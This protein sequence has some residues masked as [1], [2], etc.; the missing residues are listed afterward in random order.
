M[1]RR[2]WLYVPYRGAHSYRVLPLDFVRGTYWLHEEGDS[3]ILRG[4]K[5]DLVWL[6]YGANITAL[7]RTPV[8]C[9]YAGQGAER[10]E[11][12]REGCGTYRAVGYGYCNDKDL[13]CAA[14][15]KAGECTGTNSEV[16]KQKCPHTCGVCTHICS[17]LKKDCDGW[18]RAGECKNSPDFMLAQCPTSCGLC[19]P[20]CADIHTNCNSWKSSGHAWLLRVRLSFIV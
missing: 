9:I 18:R 11:F 20:Q 4:E 14:W 5:E 15:G 3:T 10:A 2:P 12:K 1:R 13:S 8:I 16:V 6:L 19:S 7:R 17:D